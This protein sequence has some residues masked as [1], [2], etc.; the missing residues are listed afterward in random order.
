MMREARGLQPGT[1]SAIDR[2]IGVRLELLMG[3]AD[4]RNLPE[5]PVTQ[6]EL[7]DVVKDL[8]EPMILGMDLRVAT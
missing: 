3:G 8:G 6:D 7:V 1:R 4:W 2:A 5:F